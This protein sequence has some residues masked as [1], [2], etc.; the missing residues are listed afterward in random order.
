MS[1]LRLSKREYL[2]TNVI[3]RFMSVQNSPE[4][5][6]PKQ[7]KRDSYVENGMSNLERKKSSE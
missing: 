6:F 7:F 3:K 5:N 2:A 4:A 1:R